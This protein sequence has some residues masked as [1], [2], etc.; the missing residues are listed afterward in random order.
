MT[1]DD[2]EADS[3]SQERGQTPYEDKQERFLQ[4]QS[5]PSLGKPTRK[6][7]F[8]IEDVL[9]MVL[10]LLYLLFAIVTVANE[11]IS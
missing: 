6:K 5:P 4:Q 9:I 7:E 2:W 10:S 8:N 3:R 1:G 11:S